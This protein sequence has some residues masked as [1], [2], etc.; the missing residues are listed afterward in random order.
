[1]STLKALRDRK[2][3]VQSTR[4]ITMAMKMVAG[5]KLRRAAERVEAGRPYAHLMYEILSDLALRT[6]ALEAHQPLLLGTGKMDAHLLLVMT[7]DR[8][9]C[10]SFNASIIRHARKIIKDSQEQG[11]TIK[12]FCI[13]RKGKSLLEKEYG[14]LIVESFTDLGHPRLH[15]SDAQYI[16]DTLLKMFEDGLFD[17]CTLI[18]NH[19]KSALRQENMAQ[20]IIPLR[21]EKIGEKPLPSKAICEYEP[22]ETHILNQ[23]LPQNITV[24]IYN[25]LLENAA[26]EEG[27]RMTAMDSATRNADDMLNK[28]SLTYNRTRQMHI[29]R[30]LIEIISG[31]EVLA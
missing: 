3:T 24:Q 17:M 25:A 8:G 15:F 7:S 28:L 20:Q 1:M 29:T 4:K 13:G 23:L 14:S 6:Q 19:F 31:A 21:I 9:L 11:Q 30:E 18:Y 12:L 16:T 26:S 22:N 10:G 5:A 2:E 27:A